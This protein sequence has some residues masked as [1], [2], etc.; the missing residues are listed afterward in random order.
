MKHPFGSFLGLALAAGSFATPARAVVT[1]DY[2]VVGNAGNA[3]DTAD[4]DIY[5]PGVQRYGAVPYDYKIAK[6]E[7]TVGQYAEFLNA[8]AKTDLHGLYNPAMASTTHIAGISRNGSAGSY[9]YV[10]VTGSENKPITFV[11]WFDAARF[12]NWL[13]NGQGSGGTETGAYTLNG[14]MSGIYAV[15]P[16]A[17]AWLPTEDEWYKAAYYDASKN[18]GAGGYW[19]MPT[20][21]DSLS[22]N[23]IGTPGAANY[24]DGDHVGYPNMALTDVGAYGA[25]SDSFYGTN[26]QGGNVYEWNGAE[27]GG[28]WRGVRGGAWNNSGVLDAESSRHY[29]DDPTVEDHVYGFRVAIV[30][31]PTSLVLTMLASGLLLIRRKR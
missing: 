15:N 5:T 20:Q 4:G 7:T 31:E 19:K 22:G 13:H 8:A 18:A 3:A 29:D 2:V 6:N 9:S 10:P 27:V 1:I 30:P 14:A 25:N 16:G 12:C 17:L 11:S 24:Y 23:T 28:Q 21:S 26:D